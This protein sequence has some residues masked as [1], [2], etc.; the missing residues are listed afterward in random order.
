MSSETVYLLLPEE[1]LALLATLI[2][3]GGAFLPARRG[4]SWLAASSILLSGVA[5]YE[6]G[7]AHPAYDPAG[8]IS[9]DLFST[10]LRWAILGVGLVFVVL[11]AR[12]S[13]DDESSEFMGSLLMIIVG[14]MLVALANDLV[15]F[16]VGLELISIPTYLLLFLGRSEGRLESGT[17]YFFLSILS[18]ALLLYGF[19]FLYGAGGSTSLGAIRATLAAAG[20]EGAGTTAFAPLALILIFAGIGFRL[21]AVPFHF[22]APDVYQGATNPN[23]GLLAVIPKIAALLVLVRIVFV[24]MPGYERLGW[25]LSLSVAMVTMTLGNLL[26]LWQGNVRRL[27]AYSSIAHAGY[28]LIGLA[29]GFAVAAG[30]S[31]AEAFDGIGA[32]LFYLLVYAAATA[33][34]FAALTYLGSERRSVDT[35]DELAGLSGNHPKTAA[36]LAVFMFSLTGLPPLAGFWGK[37][38]LFTGAL[39]VD[40][41][42]P[43]TGNLWPWFLALAI[44]GAL[45][46]AIS[47]GYYLRIVGLMYFRP[48]LRSADGRGGAGAALAMAVCALLVIGIGCYPGPA[49][50]QAKRASRAA[51]AA[52]IQPTAK[53]D[54]MSGADASPAALSVL[55]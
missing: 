2:Y 14:T 47:A 35:L 21:T 41:R 55:P 27:L 48:A 15:L 33:G 37:F 23:A 46:A 50:E 36:A 39:G 24:A 38:T 49:V 45:N 3:L 28:M 5:L 26:A 53:A 7:S 52:W 31:E 17:K 1:I 6:Q 4:W 12:R 16:F 42:N 51:R 13:E 54:V 40:A 11:A 29:V 43:E 34:S 9:V 20:P 30:A 32:T 19:S 18:S 25:Q 44:V 22:Y 10:T 8:P